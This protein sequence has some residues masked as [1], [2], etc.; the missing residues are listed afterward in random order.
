PP[1]VL[2]VDA[3]PWA[4]VTEVTDEA[5]NQFLAS[6]A[7]TP[8]RLTVDPGSYRISLRNEQT[9]QQLTAE[10]TA[11]ETVTRVA[12]FSETDIDDF[13]RGLGF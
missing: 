8:L 1:G 7:Y 9:E 6:P 4:Q 11:S 2:I 12:E 13:F 5:G 3:R 10:V